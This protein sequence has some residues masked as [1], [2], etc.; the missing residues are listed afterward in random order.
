MIDQLKKRFAQGV[1]SLIACESLDIKGDVKF[2]AGVV[3][4][5]KVKIVNRGKK[6]YTVPQ[7][8]VIDGA[9]LEGG[10]MTIDD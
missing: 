10:R 9:D 7:G 2:E 1:P 6:Q 4:R 5:G 3:I 8:T